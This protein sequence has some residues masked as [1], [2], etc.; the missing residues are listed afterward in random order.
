MND[1]VL[2]LLSRHDP[3]D[4]DAVRSSGAPQEDLAAILAT[5]RD[6]KGKPNRSR[7]ATRPSKVAGVALAAAVLISG[8]FALLPLDASRDGGGNPSDVVRALESAAAVAAA[9]ASSSAE[10]PYTY[11]RVEEIVVGF[12][13]GQPPFSV[14]FPSEIEEWVAED[15]SGRVRETFGE[16]RWPGP[17]DEERWRSG[18]SE[19]LPLFHPE[20]PTDRQFGPGELNA[21]PYEAALPA[22]S[23]LPADSEELL[24]IFAAEAA[25]SSPSVPRNV[26]MFEYATSVLLQRG[27]RP[28]LRAATY[29]AISRIEGV[30]L[31]GEVR[32]PRGRPGTAVGITSDYSGPTRNT[33]IFDSKTSHP[34]AVTEELLEPSNSIDSLTL[35]STTLEEVA[36]VDSLDERPS[37]GTPATVAP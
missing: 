37:S 10:S 18:G 31:Y 1:D 5:A 28:D 12:F 11:Y 27:A 19:R 36:P 24:A 15:G 6:R 7:L 8:A 25:R 16:P 13:V 29:E 22:T 2:A 17:R 4:A 23:D 35:G 20:E 30:E 26:K 33:I 34:L 3:V 14:Y 9:D 21:R 32:D